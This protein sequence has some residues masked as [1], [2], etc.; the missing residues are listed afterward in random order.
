MKVL[1]NT[2]LGGFQ[3]C[4]EGFINFCKKKG[5]ECYFYQVM[6]SFSDD[7]YYKLCQSSKDFVNLDD[8]AWGVYVTKNVGE[9]VKSVDKNLVYDN[10]MDLEWFY[11]DVPRHDPDLID[12]AE[13]Y[14]HSY[15]KV[16]E[17]P[18][19]LNYEIISDGFGGEFIIEKGRIWC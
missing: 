1:I 19:R 2:V 17:I 4:R 13:K 16:V 3:F 9:V 5:I 6:G 15:I 12:V 10:V 14:G 7:S 18:D 11:R 8:C